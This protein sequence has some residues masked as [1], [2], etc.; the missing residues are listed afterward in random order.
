MP[1]GTR[2]SRIASRQLRRKNASSP[3]NTYP[4]L[5]RRV[6]TSWTKRS[7][8]AKARTLEGLEDVADQ[9]AREVA[10]QPLQR[11]PLLFEEAGQL[12]G[13]LVLVAED[14]VGIA[15]EDA[16]VARGQRDLDDERDQAGGSAPGHRV[17]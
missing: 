6:L 11:R 1:S 15:V 2:C 17:V 12:V 7:T 10:L 14:I 5:S 8:G 13:D 16:A 3:M 9:R 4:G